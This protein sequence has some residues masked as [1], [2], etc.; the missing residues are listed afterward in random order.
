[1]KILKIVLTLSLLIVSISSCNNED[2]T[3][4]SSKEND[5]HLM[6]K[7]CYKNYKQGLLSN[8]G[9]QTVRFVSQSGIDYYD[10]L[11]LDVIESDSTTVAS[12]SMIDKLMILSLRW[13]LTP[14]QI[15]ELSESKE[16]LFEYG[17][18][19]GLIGQDI[20][21]SSE[22]GRISISGD[23]ATARIFKN[24]QEIPMQ[25]KFVKEEG[26][27]KFDVKYIIER[28]EAGLQQYLIQSGVSEEQYI[29]NVLSE[30]SESPV[31][32]V[33]WNPIKN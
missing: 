18:A 2:E 33:I 17:V 27:W 8:N 19:N 13:R 3:M 10:K 31:T 26:N 22:L 29:M 15:L 24:G 30:M 12:K 1:M 6:V 28:S 14:N 5:P 9:G 32:D 20:I 21:E 4:N 11:L 23:K 7:E 16:S 25:F